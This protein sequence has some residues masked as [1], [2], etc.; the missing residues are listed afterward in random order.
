MRSPEVAGVAL[1]TNW[2][3]RTSRIASPRTP[4]KP[5]R[6]PPTRTGRAFPPTAGRLLPMCRWAQLR[7]RRPPLGHPAAEMEPVERGRLPVHRDLV[8]GPAVVIGVATL[9][10]RAAM[11]WKSRVSPVAPGGDRPGVWDRSV[12]P[13]RVQVRAARDHA[14]KEGGIDWQRRQPLVEVPLPRK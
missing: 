12:R 2:T 10:G 4:S 9:G 14:R 8:G 3:A 5:G 6:C 7:P 11:P 1:P 13:F